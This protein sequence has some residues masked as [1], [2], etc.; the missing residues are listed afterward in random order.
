MAC[1]LHF[2]PANHALLSA[3]RNCPAVAADDASR[4]RRPATPSLV[5]NHD[6]RCRRGR[7]WHIRRARFGLPLGSGASSR[8]GEWRWKS[9]P[10]IRFEGAPFGLAEQERSEQFRHPHDRSDGSAC[11]AHYAVEQH[12]RKSVGC[13]YRFEPAGPNEQAGPNDSGDSSRSSRIPGPDLAHARDHRDSERAGAIDSSF[14]IAGAG[15]EPVGHQHRTQPER[16]LYSV[17]RCGPDLQRIGPGASA[18]KSRYRPV[19]FRQSAGRRGC[20]RFQPGAVPRRRQ[21]G[22]RFIFGCRSEFSSVASARF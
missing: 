1:G 15:R 5:A 17:G 4:R 21:P 11:V 18:T 19:R 14:A 6:A 9:R 8:A 20:K 12:R 2:R 3:S 22:G 10:A 7:Q 13:A 16:D